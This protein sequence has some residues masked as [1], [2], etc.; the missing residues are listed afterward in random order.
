MRITN[1]NPQDR[2]GRANVRGARREM[3]EQGVTTIDDSCRSYRAPATCRSATQLG[4]RRI[5]RDTTWAAVT[6]PK[7]GRVPG[8]DLDHGSPGF[9]GS[10]DRERSR[11]SGRTEG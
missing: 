3:C 7:R 10:K 1:S 4:R 9:V 5:R 8:A 11:W 2:Y 6:P